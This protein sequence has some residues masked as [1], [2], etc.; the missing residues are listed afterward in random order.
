MNPLQAKTGEIGQSALCK[1]LINSGV[2]DWKQP[3]GRRAVKIMASENLAPTWYPL[4]SVTQRLSSTAKTDLPHVVPF[5]AT[6]ISNC[7]AILAGADSQGRKKS[8]SEAAIVVHKLKTQI[9]TLLQDGSKEARWAAIVLVKAMVEAGEWNVLQ[10]S[11]NWVRAMLG[12]LG[13]SAYPSYL[14]LLV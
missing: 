14:P 12:F 4:R 9:S 3:F 10:A 2:S 11:G 5:L 7:G 8:D 1:S 13:V 6:T